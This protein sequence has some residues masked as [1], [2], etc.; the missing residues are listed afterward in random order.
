MPNKIKIIV[1]DDHPVFTSGMELVLK[2]MKIVS[3]ISIAS[4][5][6][7]VMTLLNKHPYDLVMMDLSMKPMDGI[8]TTQAIMKNFPEVKVIA[9]TMRDDVKSVFEMFELGATGYLLKNE[10]PN[11]IEV[12]IKQVMEGAKYISLLIRTPFLDYLVKQKSAKII[13]S[14][15]YHQ[16]KLREI[17]YLISNQFTSAEIADTISLA[18]RTIEEY[19]KEILLLTKSHNTAGIVK[20][21]IAN[22]IDQDPSLFLKF[23]AVLEKKA[24]DL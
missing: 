4:N 17:I 3:K 12:A 20:Y 7:E 15:V 22:N 23:K 11:E 9:L 14:T 5:G 8:D 6:V 10:S 21:A 16:Q 13:G 1:A 24:K 18:T 2:Q 19:R